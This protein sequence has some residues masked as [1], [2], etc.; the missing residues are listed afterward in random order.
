MSELLKGGGKVGTAPLGMYLTYTISW[1]NGDL[2]TILRKVM[3]F[4]G[5]TSYLSADILRCINL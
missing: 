4:P 3:V 5:N 1:R 2:L